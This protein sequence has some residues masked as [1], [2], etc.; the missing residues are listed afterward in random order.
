MRGNYGQNRKNKDL[1]VTEVRSPVLRHHG[2]LKSKDICDH[3]LVQ[4]LHFIKLSKKL[5]KWQEKLQLT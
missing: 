5:T 3:V 1:P 2:I 4:A